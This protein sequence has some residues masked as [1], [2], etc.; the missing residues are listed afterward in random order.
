MLFRSVFVAAPGENVV[1]AYPYNTYAACSGTSFSTPMVAGAAALAVSIR[2]TN[3]SQAAGAISHAVYIDN[4]LNHG[5]L[6]L[7]QAM[8]ALL[9]SSGG[10]WP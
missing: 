3:E 7:Y 9:A 4:T 10:L 6:D 2:S 5:R 1:T 8:Q